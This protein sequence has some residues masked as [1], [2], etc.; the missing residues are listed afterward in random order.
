M[1]GRK[2]FVFGPRIQMNLKD[3]CTFKNLVWACVKL[4]IQ[5]ED[6]RADWRTD[7]YTNVQ[8]PEVRILAFW[9]ERGTVGQYN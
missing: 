2:Y 6:R 3:I 9:M 5:L 8:I 7:W 1:D 4:E